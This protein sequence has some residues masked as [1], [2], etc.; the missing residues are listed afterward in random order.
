MSFHRVHTKS[1]QKNLE[2]FL[3]KSDF[4]NFFKMANIARNIERKLLYFSKRY[5]TL[6][7]KLI[8]ENKFQD[9]E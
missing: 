3:G 7:I 4:C 8:L 9:A 1:L 2:P 5:M 6:T